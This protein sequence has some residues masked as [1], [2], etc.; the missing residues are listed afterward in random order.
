M[1]P[2]QLEAIERSTL[3]DCIRFSEARD[4]DPAGAAQYIAA[5]R[6]QYPER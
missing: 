2:P 6:T 1:I 5:P 4:D 3:A